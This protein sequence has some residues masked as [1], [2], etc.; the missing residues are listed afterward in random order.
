VSLQQAH[1]PGP[2]AGVGGQRATSP[3]G[4]AEGS[5]P[6]LRHA[7]PLADGKRKAARAESP[8]PAEAGR[9]LWTQ[10][11]SDA[12]RAGK[13]RPVLGMAPQ[14]A[15]PVAATPDAESAH[16]P[17]EAGEPQGAA[18][19]GMKDRWRAPAGGT[20]H[21]EPAAVAVHRRR[22]KAASQRVRQRKGQ[23]GRRPMLPPA[24][25]RH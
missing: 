21:A 25:A 4:E 19:C 13:G 2:G 9:H 8:S 5:G 11:P 10:P 14:T 1:D 17:A 15:K 7:G 3:W 22:G 24:Q 6:V 18:D 16:L 23:Q 20:A 12:A